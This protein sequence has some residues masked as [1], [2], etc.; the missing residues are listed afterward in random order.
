M[1]SDDMMEWRR[2]REDDGPI[3]AFLR[4]YPDHPYAKNM[5]DWAD[6]IDL[7]DRELQLANRLNMPASSE[8]EKIARLALKDEELG[9]LADARNHWEDLLKHKD[10][11]DVVLHSWALVA[12][13]HVNEFDAVYE[14]YDRLKT[15]FKNDEGKDGKEKGESKVET[16]ALEAIRLE[17]EKSGNAGGKWKDLKEKADQ[18]NLRRWYLLAAMRCRDLEVTATKPGS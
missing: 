2:A 14:L 5:R 10:S 16:L 8:E 6:Q 17:N 9:K 15:K 7:K 18:D 13:K 1:S 3:A 11:T 4:Y 12:R